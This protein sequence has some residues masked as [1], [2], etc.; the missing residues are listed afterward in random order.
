MLKLSS[1]DEEKRSPFECGFLTTEKNRRQVCVRFLRI[2]ILFL[3]LDLEIA[4]IIPVFRKLSLAVFNFLYL[5]GFLLLIL[6]LVGF[7]LL[8]EYNLGGLE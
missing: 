3:L 2:A 6:L 4:I 8:L 5:L 1:K 7:L